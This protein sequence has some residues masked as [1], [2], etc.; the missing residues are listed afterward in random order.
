MSAGDPSSGIIALIGIPTIGLGIS[1][2][3]GALLGIAFERHP[4]PP[5]VWFSGSDTLTW[6]IIGPRSPF[7]LAFWG[8]AVIL[9]GLSMTNKRFSE[10][11]KTMDFSY[12]LYLYQMPIMQ[13]VIAA[14]FAVWSPA[15]VVFVL[16][17]FC[18]VLSLL[19]AWLSWRS[20][21]RPSINYA[22]Q[23]SRH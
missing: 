21:E 12:D 5:N 22:R 6:V 10:I 7:G 3:T 11:G 16:T 9:L 1:F 13:G 4:M 18:V 2:L 14:V 20:V 23:L 15:L 8:I 19:F 17:P